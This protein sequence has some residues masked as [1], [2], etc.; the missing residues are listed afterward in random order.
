MADARERL[1]RKVALERLSSPERL[2][3]MMQVITP[4]AWLALLPLLVLI[5]LAIAW[6]VLGSVPTKVAGRCILIN[7]TGLADVPSVSAGRITELTVQVGDTLKTGQVIGTVAQPD[8]ADRIERAQSRL[9]ELEAQDR[10]LRNFTSQG[11]TLNARA[12][13]QQKQNLGSQLKAAED[14]ERLARERADTQVRL[15]EQGLVTRQSLLLTRQEET[16]ARLEAEALRNQIRDIDLR[17]LE[18]QKQASSD[19][20]QSEERINEAQRQLDSLRAARTEATQIVSAFDGRV[21]EI[22]ASAG[23]LI[24]AGAS[25]LAVERTEAEAGGLIALA[26]LPP[27][28]GKRVRQG[29]EA[30][31]VPATVRREELGFVRAK[32]ASVSE[33]PST[34]ESMMRTLRNETLVRELSGGSAPLEVRAPLLRGADGRLAW[35][36]AAGSAQEIRSGTLCHAEFVVQ[37]QRPIAM[38]VPILRKSVGID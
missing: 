25:V 10:V 34:F 5:A 15:L 8:L 37:R 1:F 24:G 36:S 27:G 23:M 31:V 32:V 33:Y 6:S 35:S 28:D 12:R 14:R 22:K 30:E 9:R 38:V 2:D 3:T 17:R 16:A 18:T 13:D 21:V 7:P 20:A 19:L 26:Y 4:G 29:M 11:T